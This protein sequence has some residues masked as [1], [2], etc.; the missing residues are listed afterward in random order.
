MKTRILV[1]D[2]RRDVRHVNQHFLEKAGAEG[3]AAE[4][5]QLGID[6]ALKA[7]GVGQPFALVVTDVPMP[8]FDGRQAFAAPR[9]VE[10][11]E[12]KDYVGVTWNSREWECVK[13]F[14]IFSSNEL[15]N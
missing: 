9:S 6:A 3:R 15:Y 13:H 14:K 4:D 7:R 12:A 8:K 5:G 11:V 10:E 2:D 1:V